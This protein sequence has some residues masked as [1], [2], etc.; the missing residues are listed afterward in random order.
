MNNTEKEKIGAF[1][2]Y[3]SIIRP[4]SMT[5]HIFWLF[6]LCLCVLFYLP[7]FLTP[8]MKG[9]TNYAD[10]IGRVMGVTLLI[11]GIII[12]PILIKLYAEEPGKSLYLTELLKYTYAFLLMG[13]MWYKVVEVMYGLRDSLIQLCIPIIVALIGL[14]FTHYT[15]KDW[16]RKGK[17]IGYEGKLG[18]KIAYSTTGAGLIIYAAIGAVL[19]NVASLN[20]LVI[21]SVGAIIYIPNMIMLYYLKLR[22]AKK[23]GLEAYL[24]DGPL[25]SE[26]T[27]EE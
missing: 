18:K 1:I 24:P 19:R 3:H 13:I 5:T 17:F 2:S 4:V 15:V 16:I 21:I 11:V 12:R 22:Y 14:E 26:Y 23:Y 7:L 8:A 20:I 10:P 9:E 25:P 6:A 27:G